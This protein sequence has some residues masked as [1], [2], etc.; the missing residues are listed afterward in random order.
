MTCSSNFETKP[1]SI[2]YISPKKMKQ[3]FWHAIEKEFSS[4]A[5]YI[6]IGNSK[7]LEQIFW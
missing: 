3:Y 4:F 5:K 1:L 6:A 7:H 2:I